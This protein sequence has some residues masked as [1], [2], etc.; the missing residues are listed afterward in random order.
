MSP[1]GRAGMSSK[2]E[3]SE[4][5]RS[6]VSASQGASEYRPHCLDSGWHPTCARVLGRKEAKG[7]LTSV[8]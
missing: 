2:A 8:S 1:G 5:L 7:E 3:G 4:E 6:G